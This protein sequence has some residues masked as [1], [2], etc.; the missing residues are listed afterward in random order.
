M[1]VMVFIRSVDG[2]LSVGVPVTIYQGQ[3]DLICCTL[4]V[5]S[6]LKRL[7]WPGLAAFQAAPQEPFYAHGARR[8]DDKTAGFVRR[9]ENLAMY[10]IMSA[11]A[12]R[13]VSGS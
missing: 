11:G 6:W 1:V 7:K 5:D 8:E 4:G 9:H 3:L 13:L 10:Y 12:S 2:T